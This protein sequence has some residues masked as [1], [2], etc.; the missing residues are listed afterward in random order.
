V[1][2]GTSCSSGTAISQQ[3]D[4]AAAA[5]AAAAAYVSVLQEGLMRKRIAS[6]N[7][8]AISADQR[9]IAVDD[10]AVLHNSWLQ[11][12]GLSDEVAG[13]SFPLGG[14]SSTCY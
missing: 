5:A 6:I 1:A 12:Q 11:E 3:T 9:R 8:A 4:A 7:E 10:T 2:R 13:G 14:G